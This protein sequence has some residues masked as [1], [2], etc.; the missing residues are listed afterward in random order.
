MNRLWALLSA[1]VLTALPS[2]ASAAPWWQSFEDPHLNEVIEQALHGHEVGI[3]TLGHRNP[4]RLDRPHAREIVY[5][6]ILFG[7]VAG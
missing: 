3:A 1:T 6:G 4:Q 7:I 2:L 5:E